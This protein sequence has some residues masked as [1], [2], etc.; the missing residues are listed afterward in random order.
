MPILD[1][2]VSQFP[3]HLLED[4]RSLGSDR[5]WWV[6]YTMARQEKALARRLLRWQIPFFLPLT[7]KDNYF[8]GRRIRS[9]IPLFSGYVFL[10]ARADER[11]LALGTN[12][13]SSMLSVADQEQLFRDLRQVHHLVTSG[14]QVTFESHLVPG[15]RVAVKA[16]AMMGLEGTVISR[17]GQSRIVIAVNFLQ[18]GAS[19]AIDSSLLEAIDG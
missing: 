4:C 15:Q 9:H 17:R 10:F 8:R 12:R 1:T 3:E 14:L 2:E 7:P 19:I 6:A 13:I 18:K 11:M 5:C 16:G